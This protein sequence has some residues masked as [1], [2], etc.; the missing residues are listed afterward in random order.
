MFALVQAGILRPQ[1][2]A[3]LIGYW[4]SHDTK[5]KKN[6]RECLA[7]A[8]IS[9]YTENNFVEDYIFLSLVTRSDEE[10]ASEMLPFQHLTVAIR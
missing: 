4:K 9:G 3:D 5:F 10:I 1:G 6:L 8:K 7:R 2:A